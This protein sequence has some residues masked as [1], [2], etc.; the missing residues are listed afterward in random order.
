[1][2]PKQQNEPH[3]GGGAVIASDVDTRGGDFIGRDKITVI[4]STSNRVLDALGNRTPAPD[5][6]EATRR[7]LQY[8]VDRY[9]YLSLKG[10]GVSDRVALRLPLLDLY[11]PLK[12]RLELPP[13]ET[14]NRLLRLAGR[15]MDEDGPQALAGR[16]SEPQPVLE[17]LQKQDGLIILGDP[18]AGKTTFLKYLVLKLAQGEGRELSLGDRLP[19]LVPLSGYANALEE[20]DV[21]LDDYIARFYH[22]LGADLPVKE[23]LAE[24]LAGGGALVLLDGL[25]EVRRTGL[26]HTVVERVVDFF[27][28]HRRAGNKFLLTS[29]II[30][31][32]EVR[33]TAE[34]LAECTLVDFD[35]DE[36]GDFVTRWTAALERQA[37]GDTRFA[38]M[39]ADSER[40]GLLEAVN[41]NPG[42]RHLAANPL[43]L[44]ILALMKRQGIILPERR[45]ELYD[46]Y[47]KTLLSSWNRTRSLGRPPSRDL[48]VVQT[49]KILAPLALWMHQ[50]N[51]GVGLVKREELRR[52]LQNIY[53]RRK[54]ADPEGRAEQFLEDVRECAGLLLERGPGEYGFIHLTFE[55]YLAA[56]A[57]A[58]DWQGDAAAIAR[59][60]GGHISDP[61]W[62]EIILLTV[63][64]VGLIQQ[65]DQVAGGVVEALVADRPGAPGEAIVL[66]GEAVADAGPAGVP[67]ASRDKVAAALIEAMQD[68]AVAPIL[69]RR[70]GLALGRLGWRPEDLDEFVEVPPGRFLYGDDRQ[71]R[72]ISY[73]YW[74]A[75]YPVTCLQYARFMAD[76]GY[77]RRDFWSEAGWRW[78]QDNER[79]QS[80]YWN[81]IAGSNPLFPI[82]GASLY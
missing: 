37:Q 17:W 12:A 62:R 41:R 75:R 38:Q 65:L 43:L 30:G 71:P 47:V 28:L 59:A 60:L 5:L 25:D 3:T 27:A 56:V 64:Y 29:R 23:L 34:G 31:Y 66:A 76:N 16:L 52:E 1:M 26:R 42:V 6:R 58:Q 20:A 36:I 46:Q 69:R 67:A 4:L 48:D 9:Q 39:D 77:G 8:L 10:L 54:E 14:W 80:E 24:A 44:T 19:I 55:E 82:I 72:E 49:I 78:R 79:E 50:E 68:G 57:I 11:V 18:G 7:Y 74:I 70:A 32:R 81:Y 33:P 21:R 63:G 15:R 2:D 45:V 61:L 73:R 40:Q 51:P 13:G 22:D 35:D 53:R